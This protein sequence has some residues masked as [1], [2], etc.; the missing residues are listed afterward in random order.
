MYIEMKCSSVCDFFIGDASFLSSTVPKDTKS[1][2]DS[3]SSRDIDNH[4]VTDA[5][6]ESEP[7]K[8][9]ESAADTLPTQ[10]TSEKVK[11]KKTKSKKR[12]EKTEIGGGGTGDGTSAAELD[13]TAPQRPVVAT[14]E[15]GGGG[16]R[17]RKVRNEGQVVRSEDVD[18]YCGSLPVDD[19]IEFIDCGRKL[20]RSRSQ[21]DPGSLTEVEK[22]QSMKKETVRDAAVENDSGFGDVEIPDRTDASH[23]DGALSPSVSSVAESVEVVV[24]LLSD[25]LNPT[26][27]QSTETR[28]DSLITEI[29][30]NATP[31]WNIDSDLS[32][33]A[34]FLSDE[35]FTQPELEFT[36]VR[37]KK[38]RAKGQKTVPPKDTV[39][40]DKTGCHMALPTHSN[41]IVCSSAS[42]ERSNSPQ[43]VATVN[44]CTVN[45]HTGR[46]MSDTQG[47]TR[48]DTTSFRRYNSESKW[49]GRHPRFQPLQDTSTELRPVY[50]QTRATRWMT[51]RGGKY[52]PYGTSTQPREVEKMNDRKYNMSVGIRHGNHLPDVI[53]RQADKPCLSSAAKVVMQDAHC[54]TVDDAISE[55]SDPDSSADTGR[56][57][58]PFDLLTLQLFMYHG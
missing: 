6:G 18:G 13:V 33:A 24:E 20:W 15:S 28:E 55:S 47:N 21:P 44:E 1:S 53:P 45:V 50:T 51:A 37:Q 5:V 17:S 40:V 9:T 2:E 52:I 43:S 56:T 29:S 36:V 48:N 3:N 39:S 7:Q 14:D 49:R 42:S 35:E 26:A 8:L 11:K 38:R 4:V 46:Q 57:Q 16:K 12:S 41:S 23:S 31:E 27:E 32:Y 22:V 30:A 54:Q 19:L 34:A 10:Q 25:S 58:V